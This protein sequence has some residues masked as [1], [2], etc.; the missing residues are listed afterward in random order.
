[1]KRGQDHLDSP[2]RP[3]KKERLTPVLD[4]DWL[5]DGIHDMKTQISDLKKEVNKLETEIEGVKDCIMGIG[6]YLK[7][8]VEFGL[9]EILDLLRELTDRKD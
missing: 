4:G 8:E 9:T 1:L 7:E 2:V 5:R 3:S 6:E